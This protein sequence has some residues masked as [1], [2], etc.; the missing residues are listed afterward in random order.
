LPRRRLHDLSYNPAVPAH[1]A[2]APGL[3]RRRLHDL[4]YNPAAPAHLAEA[5]GLPRR[6]LHDRSY[7]PAAPAHRAEAPGLPRRRLHDLSYPPADLP[8]LL[9]DECP[10]VVLVGQDAEQVSNC[11]IRSAPTARPRIRAETKRGGQGTIWE[12]LGCQQ[13]GWQCD[14]R[15][16]PPRST[17]LATNTASSNALG[18]NPATAPASTAVRAV[19]TKG[20]E[21][22]SGSE[23]VAGAARSG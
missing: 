15:L 12:P 2:E 23:L 22:P 3:P 8:S 6:R 17:I 10:T 20:Q 11:L 13:P 1:L 18:L 4:S 7:N 16:R 14:G 5:P 19:S 21:S 9:A